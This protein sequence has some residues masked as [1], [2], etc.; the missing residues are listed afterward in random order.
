MLADTVGRRRVWLW[1][2]SDII[3]WLSKSRL[4][5]GWS[6]DR[7]RLVGAQGI[8]GFGMHFGNARPVDGNDIVLS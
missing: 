1:D 4:R 7:A 6:G 5:S 8:V 3:G 2:F